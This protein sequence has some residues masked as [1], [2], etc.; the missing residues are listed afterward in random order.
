[1][2]WNPNA[3]IDDGSCVYFV[4]SCSFLGNEGWDE[5]AAG[6]YADSAMWHYVGS[7]ASGEW[8][9][10]LPTIIQEPSSGS[11]FAVSSWSGLSMTNLP[12]GLEVADF[13][14]SLDGGEQACL[15]YSGVPTTAGQ[16]PIMVSG[17]LTVLL[18]GSPYEVGNFSV[19][20]SMDIFPNPNP[21]PGCTYSNAANFVLFA[22]QD[23]GSCEFLGCMDNMASNY[24][25]LATVD[26]GTCLYD[27][28][29]S[30][31]PSDIDQDGAVTTSDLL[32]LLSTFGLDCQ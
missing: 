3:S 16:Y 28:C 25:P 21:I 19:V 4:S 2:N 17:N 27:E 20:A 12:P 26:D 29:V 15:S 5:L 13:P 31:C 30:T 23:D 8:V 10:S 6:L 11:M 7:E 14:E 1:M 9:L 32:N 24:Q 18:F 22:N